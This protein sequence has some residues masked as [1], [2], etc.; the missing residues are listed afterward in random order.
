MVIMWQWKGFC[1]L[2]GKVRDI[3]WHVLI[4]LQ[5]QICNMKIGSRAS[6]YD[7]GRNTI[8]FKEH[9]GTLDKW[10]DW[11]FVAVDNALHQFVADHKVCC[12]GVLIN[13]KQ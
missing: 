6:G 12:T 4:H 13:Q 11:F 8:L 9:S 1:F 10:C 5:N 3:K 2:L 7:D